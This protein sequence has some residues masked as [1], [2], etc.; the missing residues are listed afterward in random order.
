MDFKKSGIAG[1]RNHCLNR[2]F[3]A[4]SKAYFVDSVECRSGTGFSC[5]FIPIFLS[6]NFIQTIEK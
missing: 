1:I 2:L 5:T 4:I 3:S 6:D